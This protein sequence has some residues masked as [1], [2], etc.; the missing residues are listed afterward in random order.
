MPEMTTGQGGAGSDARGWDE[1][2]Y[3]KSI[4]RERELRCRTVFRT[5]FSPS[6]NP[7]PETLVVASSDGSLASYSLASC[8]ASMYQHPQVDTVTEQWAAADPLLAEPHSIIQAHKGPIYDLKFYRHGDDCLLFSCGDDGRLRAWNWKELLSS[9]IVADRQGNSLKPILDLA[10]PQHEGP[11]GA[12]SPIPENNAITVN[13]QDGSVYSAAGDARAY[14]WDIETGKQKMVFKGHVDYLHCITAHKSSHQII[15][16]SEDGTTRIWDCR[17]GLCTQI[18]HPGKNF[19][20]EQSS[21]VS[22]IDID[23]S[24]SWLACGT[25]TGLSVWSLLSYE[26]IFSMGHFAPVQD[27]LFDNNQIVAVGSEPVL[28]RFSINGTTLSQLKCAPQSAFSVS[29]HHPSGVIAVGG[30]GAL[31]DVLTQFGSHLCTFRC[32]GLDNYS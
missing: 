14:S 9:H 30:Y 2:G 5:A 24:E 17:S 15:T 25:G 26:C 3:K 4:L 32:P 12:L 23:S 27:L 8:I 1:E 31:V 18:I 13:E 29:L 7:N 16:G 6:S 21:W 10:N 28:T 11:W 20:S 22:C 19:K